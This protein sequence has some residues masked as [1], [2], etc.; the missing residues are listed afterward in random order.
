MEVSGHLS[1]GAPL[2]MK[3]QIAE[4][5]AEAGVIGTMDVSAEAGVNLVTTS[6]AV[7]M[8]GLTLDTG[9]YSVAQGVANNI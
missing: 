9:T 5:L 6:N 4:T 3:Y 8:V 7:D 2:L 1:G